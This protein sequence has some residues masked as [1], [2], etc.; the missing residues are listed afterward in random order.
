MAALAP[1]QLNSRWSKVTKARGSSSKNCLNITVLLLAPF[2]F[3]NGSFKCPPPHTRPRWNSFSYLR[4]MIMPQTASRPPNLLRGT[5]F[6]SCLAQ[7]MTSSH[8]TTMHPVNQPHPRRPRPSSLSLSR[9]S[10]P[11]G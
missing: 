2:C 6:H 7:H 8:H 3:K 1:N 11:S 4:V 5:C 10:S 9:P